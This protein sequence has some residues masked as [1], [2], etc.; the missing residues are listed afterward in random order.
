[1]IKYS[2]I[3]EKE[4]VHIMDSRK[5]AGKGLFLLFLGQ[6]LVIVAAILSAVPVLG[7]I[8]AIAALACSIYGLY[9]ASAAHESYRTAFMAQVAL[10]VLAIISIFIPEGLF[11]TIFS[12]ASD[13]LSMAVVYLVCSA[14]SALLI[15]LDSALENRGALIWKLYLG[16]TLLNIILSLLVLVPIIKIFAAILMVLSFIVL[17]V[18]SILYMVFLYKSQ[19]VLQGEA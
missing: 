10:L 8:L 6:I 18:A 1:M 12:L 14:T 16:C 7:L 3:I 13:V 15:G 5:T 4:E 11:S 19:A 2:H 17:L 9:V